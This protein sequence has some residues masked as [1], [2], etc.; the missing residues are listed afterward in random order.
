MKM[1]KNEKAQADELE[2]IRKEALEMKSKK[3]GWTGFMS[4]Q[5]TKDKI[6][7]EVEEF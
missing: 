5:A 2:K 6:K 3:M 1:L 4:S 7:Q